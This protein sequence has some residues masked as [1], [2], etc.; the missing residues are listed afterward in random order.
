MCVLKSGIKINKLQLAKQRTLLYN[1]IQC[2]VTQI[3]YAGIAQLVAQ[4]I[5]NQ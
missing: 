3:I 5:R 2:R 4:L 1:T